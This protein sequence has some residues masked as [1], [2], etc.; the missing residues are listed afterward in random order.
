MPKISLA[1]MENRVREANPNMQRSTV[2][3]LGK[4]AKKRFDAFTREPTEQ[5]VLEIFKAIVYADETGDTAV[6]HL[7]NPAE[8]EHLASVRRRLAVAA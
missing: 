6:R 5:E 4:L 2:K 8:C 3:K 7:M 1:T